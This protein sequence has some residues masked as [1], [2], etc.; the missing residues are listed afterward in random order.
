M[1]NIVL[2]LIFVYLAY[3]LANFLKRLFASNAN[4][5]TSQK[6]HGTAN[7]RTKIDKKDVIDAQ[8]EE[9]DINDKSTQAE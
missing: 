7:I 1:R 5:E 2:F 4:D 6:V 8:F 3:K 9:I